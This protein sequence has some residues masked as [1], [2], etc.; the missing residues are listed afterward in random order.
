MFLKI[1]Q[2]LTGKHLCCSFFFNKLA[3]LK[4][5]NFIK[6]ETPT[7]VFSSEYYEIFKNTF[8]TEHFRW[9]LLNK[10]FKV[11]MSH[12]NGNEAT[13]QRRTSLFSSIQSLRKKV[14]I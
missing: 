1:S 12:S 6:N 7:Q 13:P 10:K 14:L 9:L 2:K 3:G 8:F 4:A 5:F 11:A